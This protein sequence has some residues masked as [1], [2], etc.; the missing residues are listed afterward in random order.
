MTLARCSVI[1]EYEVRVPYV[2]TRH[3]GFQQP[4][5]AP[6]CLFLCHLLLRASSH[7]LTNSSTTAP[8]QDLHPVTLVMTHTAVYHP[9]YP[10][11]TIFQHACTCQTSSFSVPH[12]DV[13]ALCL[14]AGYFVNTF[15]TRIL[16]S[17]NGLSQVQ[18]ITDADP[19]LGC[20]LTTTSAT[21]SNKRD[22]S[23]PATTRPVDC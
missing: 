10:M 7:R 13:T 9:F 21:F 23:N 20:S 1:V 19:E 8:Q 18:A 3:L 11:S 16:T 14:V 22:P 17:C 4:R 15:K 5:D 2:G 12:S 6:S